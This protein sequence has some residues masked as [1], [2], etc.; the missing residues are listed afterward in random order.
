MYWYVYLYDPAQGLKKLKTECDEE[1]GHEMGNPVNLEEFS[2][3]DG[4]DHKDKEI[5]FRVCV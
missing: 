5:P 2:E 3:V 4:N 1:Q